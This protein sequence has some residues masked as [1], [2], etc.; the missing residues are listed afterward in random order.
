MTRSHVLLP[1][2]PIACAAE[3]RKSRSTGPKEPL[4]GQLGS[5][6]STPPKRPAASFVAAWR[7]AS[8]I[9]PEPLDLFQRLPAERD[10]RI[11]WLRRAPKGGVRA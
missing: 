6:F 10:A 5:S 9:F 7:H 8:V 2:D 4:S 3:K 1:G 11:G